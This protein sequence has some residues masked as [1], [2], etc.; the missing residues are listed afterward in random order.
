MVYAGCSACGS[1]SP[2][3]HTG[4]FPAHPALPVEVGPMGPYCPSCGPLPRMTTCP[5]CFTTQP[6]YVAGMSMQQP[7]MAPPQ[8]VAPMFQAPQNAS[9]AQLQS[10]MNST[11][12]AFKSAFGREMGVQM[13]DMATDVMGGWVS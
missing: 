2:Q 4:A 6:L 10:G 5:F 1:I 11:G 7:G 12:S 3:F 8:Q 13:A 9:P